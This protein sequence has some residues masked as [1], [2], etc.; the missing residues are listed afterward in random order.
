MKV[1]G[2]KI[3]EVCRDCGKVVQINK[4]FIGGLHICTLPENHITLEQY[5]LIKQRLDS[6]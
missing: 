3:Y 2:N 4:S 6:L 5:R 1:I